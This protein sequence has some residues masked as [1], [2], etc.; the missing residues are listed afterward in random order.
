MGAV[1]ISIFLTPKW[2]QIPINMINQRFHVNPKENKVS[3][4]I[5]KCYYV[6]DTYH[7]IELVHVSKDICKSCP[8]HLILKKKLKKE[9]KKND[10]S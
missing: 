4:Y 2:N 1:F 3:K 6:H 5:Y 7:V 8:F 10:I 9:I